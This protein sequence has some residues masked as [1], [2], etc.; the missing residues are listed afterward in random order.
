[1]PA[2]SAPRALDAQGAIVGFRVDFAN[3][4]AGT[5]LG[6]PPD[7]LMGAAIPD[8]KVNPR[9]MPFVDAC[10]RV[11]ETGDP[12]AVDALA[13]AIAGPEGPA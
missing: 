9:D 3:V 8:W 1:M 6:D 13:Y 5:Y 11:V 7:K 12:L 4:V 2:W 10:R